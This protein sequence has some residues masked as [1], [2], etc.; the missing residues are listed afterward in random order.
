MGMYL[1]MAPSARQGFYNY[2]HLIDLSD[3]NISQRFLIIRLSIIRCVSHPS[4]SLAIISLTTLP[5]KGCSADGFPSPYVVFSHQAFKG[6]FDSGSVIEKVRDTLKWFFILVRPRTVV[7][8]VSLLLQH[9]FS[10]KR[11]VEGGCW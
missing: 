11:G 3:I 8:S 6:A 9:A 7:Y 10:T 5:L 1:S 2:L 4:E